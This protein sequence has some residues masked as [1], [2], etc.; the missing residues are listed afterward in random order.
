MYMTDTSNLLSH[1]TPQGSK[2]NLLWI[3]ALNSTPAPPLSASWCLE[4]GQGLA[5]ADRHNRNVCQTD[6]CDQWRKRN[7]AGAQKTSPPNVCFVRAAAPTHPCA[8]THHSGGV[9]CVPRGD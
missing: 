7:G 2:S 9:I 8:V 3:F 1:E 5:A 6:I 4:T